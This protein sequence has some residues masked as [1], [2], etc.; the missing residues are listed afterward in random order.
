MKPSDTIK[1]FLE[2]TDLAPASRKTYGYI[3]NRLF[4]YLHRTR[5]DISA[6]S[7]LGFKSLLISED[8]SELTLKTYQNCIIS[9][10]RFCLNAGL[11][12]RDPTRHLKKIPSYAGY[13]RHP[14]SSDQVNH[15]FQTV[16]GEDVRSIRNQAIIS[17]AVQ[18]G[19]RMCELS[20][21][22]IKDLEGNRLYLK[23]KG[24]LS[25]MD[26][27]KLADG[28][29]LIL[30]K[31]IATRKS[32]GEEVNDNSPLFVSHKHNMGLLGVA[33]SPA[34]MGAIV[35]N[36]LRLA[37]LK[38]A[39]VTPHSLRHTCAC[40]LLIGG[41]DIYAVS[42]TLGHRNLKSTQL[43]TQFSNEVLLAE[44]DPANTIEKM[45]FK[46]KQ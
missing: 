35:C 6:V 24:S 40:L 46:S 32:L 30:Q 10:S 1:R 8:K 45:A 19:L 7:V 14:L 39:R 16:Q 31:Y 38:H 22:R 34:G 28:A 29:L 5:Q 36:L 41:A 27:T 9:F 2:E 23:R 37:G 21:A 12:E 15:L 3:L 44:L 26:Y 43:Y 25:F 13:K 33:I 4:L 20:H 17:I 11:I 42:K 18:N